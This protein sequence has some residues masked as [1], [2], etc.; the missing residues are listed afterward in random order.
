M[1]EFAVTILCGV[2]IGIAEI[3]P[4]VSGGT[5]AVLLNIYDKLIGSISRLTKNLK[6]NLLFLA[7]LVLGMGSGIFAFSFVSS[8]LLEHFTMAVNFFFWAL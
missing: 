1:M 7:P 2:V 5:L 8:F 6:K 4:G 3:I